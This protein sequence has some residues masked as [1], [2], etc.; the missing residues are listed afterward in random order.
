MEDGDNSK[1]R[2][3]SGGC[4]VGGG[5]ETPESEQGGI[6]DNRDPVV[7]APLSRVLSRSST[8]AKTE[9]FHRRWRS[10]GLSGRVAS[11]PM[12]VET[13]RCVH[14][15]SAHSAAERRCPTTGLAIERGVVERRRSVQRQREATSLDPALEPGTVIDGRYRIVRKLGSGGMSTVVEAEVLGTVPFPANG[16]VALKV[17]HRSLSD[18]QESIARLLRE[19]DVVRTLHHEHVCAVFDMGR[20]EHG[21]PYLVMEFLRG[22]NLAERIEFGPLGVSETVATLLPVLEA[23]EAAH[24]LGVIHRDLKPDNIFILV[25]HPERGGGSKLLDFGVARNFGY[26]RDHQRLTDTGMV[27]GTPYYMAPEQARGEGKLD[28]RVDVWA[29]GVILYEALTGERPFT[30]TNYNALLVKILTQQPR[31]VTQLAPHLP[32]LMAMVVGK[33][34]AKRPEERFQTVRELGD[35]LRLVREE[36]GETWSDLDD[37]TVALPGRGRTDTPTE[38]EAIQVSG[39]GRASTVSAGATPSAAARHEGSAPSIHERR[40]AEASI[41]V[42]RNTPEGHDGGETEI[43][44]RR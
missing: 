22:Q 13:V 3:T 31:P 36:A 16:R 41:R 34:L 28:Q 35:A 29:I 6:V 33:A 2:V 14:C 30:A 40:N 17:L 4:D 32:P 26:E 11:D 21:Q 7:A 39:F 23:L 43:L 24:A 1:S 37:P 5:G 44:R 38:V 19:A 20:T 8:Q 18:N 15:G 42:A 9:L 12:S 10:F 27:M 25:G